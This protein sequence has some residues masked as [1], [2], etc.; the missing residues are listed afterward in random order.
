MNFSLEHAAGKHLHLADA[1]SRLD[2]LPD[3]KIK[4]MDTTVHEFHNSVNASSQKIQEIKA[5][6]NRLLKYL[7]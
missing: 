7:D 5:E 1:L 2:P 4:G 6:T 3:N